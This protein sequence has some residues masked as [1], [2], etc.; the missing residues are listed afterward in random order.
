MLKTTIKYTNLQNKINF[1]NKEPNKMAQ[2]PDK[3]H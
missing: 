2:Y 1:N 3:N